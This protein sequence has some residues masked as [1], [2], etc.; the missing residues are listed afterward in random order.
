MPNIQQI[1]NGEIRR[2]ARK[3]VKAAM[4]ALLKSNALLRTRISE[5]EHKVKELEKAAPQ[6]AV[7]EKAEI[8]KEPKELKFRITPARIKQLRTKLGLPQKTFAALLDVTIGTINNWEKGKSRPQMEQKIRIA[9]L[10]SAGKRELAK[11]LAAL[12]EAK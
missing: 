2:L 6:T 8:A 10:R 3:E 4:S 5:L 11:K 7:P 12:S 9:A 1:L